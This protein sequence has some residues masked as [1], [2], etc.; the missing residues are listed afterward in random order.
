ME[1]EKKVKK[2]GI[3]KIL[4][5]FIVIFG[6]GF[7]FFTSFTLGQRIAVLANPKTKSSS[8]KVTVPDEKVKSLIDEYKTM[9]QY[10]KSDG[11]TD[12][13]KFSIVFNNLKKNEKPDYK[14]SCE[15]SFEDAINNEHRAKNSIYVCE[16]NIDGYISSYD[17][18]I[19]NKYYKSIFGEDETI[20]KKDYDGSEYFGEYFEYSTKV[21]SYVELLRKYIPFNYSNIYNYYE[22]ESKKYENSRLEV[23]IAYL[24]Y[25]YK[26]VDE[27]QIYT[28]EINGEKK[29][30]ESESDLSKVYNENKD[31]LPKL[32][33]KFD[34]I[35]NNFILI[36]IE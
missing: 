19:V 16:N 20:E 35:N 5:W 28:Y 25:E 6:T 24:S 4:Y 26:E 13:I 30:V 32:T 9:F 29:N 36:S 14:Y 8:R 27:K 17:Y 10:I 3:P 31:N 12:N 7:I 33:F 11:L 34:K 23:E 15:D 18:E 2:R 21:D 1:S 22:I